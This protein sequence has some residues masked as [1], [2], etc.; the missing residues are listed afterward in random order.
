MNKNE[1]RIATIIGDNVKKHRELKEMTET[2]VAEKAGI[3]IS[4]YLNI[5]TGK[6]IPRIVTLVKVA[7]ALEVKIKK[8][9]KGIN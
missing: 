9:I 5:E 8:L 2:E 4:T 1:E 3:D 7:N 6:S